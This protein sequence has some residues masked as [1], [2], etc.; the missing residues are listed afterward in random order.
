VVVSRSFFPEGPRPRPVLSEVPV[1]GA[2][3]PQSSVSI[4]ACPMADG[5]V[6]AGR[7]TVAKHKFLY[8][9]ASPC[10]SCLLC[11]GQ[12]LTRM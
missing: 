1:V 6:V 2:I 8:A 4:G 7:P 9:Q 3:L 5:L 11:R 12:A 10:V